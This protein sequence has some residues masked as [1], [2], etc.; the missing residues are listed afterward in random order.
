ME[1]TFNS[2][3]REK[4]VNKTTT[5]CLNKLQ[6]NL[7]NG[8]RITEFYIDIEIASDVRENIEKE[9][10]GKPFNWCI[11]HRDTNPYTG[12]I[13]HFSGMRI[14]NEKYYKLEYCGN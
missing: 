1:L 2:K 12:K 7:S 11:V 10:E 6:T 4:M 13:Q 9:I 14:G 3:A 5:D 8:I